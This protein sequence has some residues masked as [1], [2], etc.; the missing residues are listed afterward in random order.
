MPTATPFNAGIGNGFT[1]CLSKVDVSSF[2]FWT[3]LSGVNKD[4]PTT[5]DVLIFESLKKAMKLF[6]NY[7]G[8]TV[9]FPLSFNDATLI[10]DIEQDEFDSGSRPAPFAPK[11]R[12]CRTNGWSFNRI[13]DPEFGDQFI[14]VE[15]DPIR[16]YNGATDDEDNFV[17]YGMN[18]GS[19]PFGHEVFFA[20]DGDVFFF[21]SYLNEDGSDSEAYEYSDAIDGIW[22]VAAAE[23]GSLTPTINGLSADFF[24]EEGLFATITYESFDFWTYPA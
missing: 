7:N 10:I 15:I 18:R 24:V 20:E 17:G 8:H 21:S 22:F 5:S 2:D 3:T 14:D 23:G 12:V 19:S 1:E 11:S 4:S 13:E 16:M 9:D 6:W